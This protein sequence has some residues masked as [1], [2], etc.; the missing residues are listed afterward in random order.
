MRLVLTATVLDCAAA[1]VVSSGGLNQ[2]LAALLARHLATDGRACLALALL[3]YPILSYPTLP[4]PP[5]RLLRPF[6][7]RRSP[8]IYACLCPTEWRGRARQWAG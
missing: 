5:P 1:A 4:Y 2:L 3:P 7:L 6:W 8:R